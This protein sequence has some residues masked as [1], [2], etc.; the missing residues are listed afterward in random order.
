MLGTI[1]IVIFLPS[2]FSKSK[3][4]FSRPISGDIHNPK[5]I[6]RKV[7][8]LEKKEKQRAES[9]VPV[10]SYVLAGVIIWIFSWAITL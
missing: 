10:L 8:S 2:V 6:F 3:S 4:V 5:V 7:D 1:P 9:I